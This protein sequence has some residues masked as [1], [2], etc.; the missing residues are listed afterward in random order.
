MGCK[1]ER[2][3]CVQNQGSVKKEEGQTDAGYVIRNIRYAMMLIILASFIYSVFRCRQF[4]PWSERKQRPRS[5]VSGTRKDAVCGLCTLSSGPQQLYNRCFLPLTL[6]WFD[7]SSGPDP[8]S[9]QLCQQPWCLLQLRPQKLSKL[10]LSQI[11]ASVGTSIVA[12]SPRLSSLNCTLGKGVKYPQ[13]RTLYQ[14]DYA[15]FLLLL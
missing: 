5:C 14:W 11:P 13:P 12:C 7:T 4:S 15:S 3:I 8:D 1:V 10:N 6:F 2:Q 9:L